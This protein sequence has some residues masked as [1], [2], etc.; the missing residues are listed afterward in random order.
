MG[1]TFATRPCLDP[2]DLLRECLDRSLPT[3][4]WFGK[5]NVYR[6]SKDRKSVV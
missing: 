2:A 6:T 3:D 1:F 4:A 5:A